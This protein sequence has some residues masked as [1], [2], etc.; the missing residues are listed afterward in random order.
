MTARRTTPLSERFPT[1]DDLL[2][3][4]DALDPD[5]LAEEIL[6]RA[7]AI[8]GREDDGGSPH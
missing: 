4:A 7:R 8:I 6:V 5:E 2:E 1:W 3:V